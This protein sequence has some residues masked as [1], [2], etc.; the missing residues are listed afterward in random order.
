VVPPS[1]R[2]G[3]EM[4]GCTVALG[5]SKKGRIMSIDINLIRADKGGDPAKVI[6]SELKRR[7]D[8]TVVQSLIE[9]DKEWRA[10]KLED[11]EDSQVQA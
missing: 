9:M 4:I 11:Y 7:K 8:V 2:I 1:L 10:G 6:A 3:K 5:H